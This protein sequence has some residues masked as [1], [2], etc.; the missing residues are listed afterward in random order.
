MLTFVP[1]EDVDQ[2]HIVW[3]ANSLLAAPIDERPESADF[4]RAV[5]TGTMRLFE[6]PQGCIFVSASDGI[7]MLQAFCTDPGISMEACRNLRA[8]LFRLA[9]DWQ[10]H[11]I[12]TICFD[13][14]FASVIKH[15]GGQVQSQTLILEVPDG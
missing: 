14:R 5:M 8:D 3:L 9:A 6:F 15:L 13:T 12:K 10:C 2:R 7:L 4:L 1:W 11:T